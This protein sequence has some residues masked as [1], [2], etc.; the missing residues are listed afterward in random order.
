MTRSE[1]GPCRRKATFPS[2]KPIYLATKWGLFRFHGL[3]LHRQHP[4]SLHCSRRN[5]LLR[6]YRR[7]AAS[8]ACSL[9]PNCAPVT[10]TLLQCRSWGA[11]VGNGTRPSCGVGSSQARSACLT[12]CRPGRCCLDGDCRLRGSRDGV[13]IMLAARPCL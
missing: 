1:N 13:S 2:P 7:R 8:L 10:V 11:A 4:S 12:E 5:C 9:P 3:L 6:R